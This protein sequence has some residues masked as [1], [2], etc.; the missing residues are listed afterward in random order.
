MAWLV[1][2]ALEFEAEADA[3]PDAVKVEMAAQAKLLAAVGPQ[4]GRPIRCAP[5]SP[6]GCIG[7]EVALGNVYEENGHGGQQ[8]CGTHAR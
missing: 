5:R 4:L 8:D 3:L 6:Q 7:E 1:R 2:F